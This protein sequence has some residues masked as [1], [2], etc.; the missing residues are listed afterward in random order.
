MKGL[1]FS[2]SLYKIAQKNIE[3]Y[4]KKT[5]ENR[6]ELIHTDVSFYQVRKEDNFFYFFHPFNEHIL[7]QCL[8]NIHTSLKKDPR[9]AL[10]IYQSNYM[11]NTQ[12]IAEGGFFQP[13]KIFTSF[14]T[15]FYVYKYNCHR[16]HK[17]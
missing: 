2:L 6:F 14:G 8:S 11:D 1:E 10:L 12:C 16:N 15:R 9:K 7:K 3:S 4:I 13:L 5:G 17:M